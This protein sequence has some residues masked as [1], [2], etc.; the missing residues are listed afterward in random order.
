MSRRI[1]S[2]GGSGDT[3]RNGA[4]RRPRSISSSG[5]LDS[6]RSGVSD[7]PGVSD[8]PGSAPSSVPSADFR[9]VS[10]VSPDASGSGTGEA[11]A[12]AAGGGADTPRGM[13]PDDIL[14]SSRSHQG[15]VDARSL[16][17]DASVPERLDAPGD[18]GAGGMLLRPKVVSYPQRRKE[19]TMAM[20]HRITRR[21]VVLMLVAVLV[22][23]GGWVLFFSP[24]FRYDPAQT[25]LSGLN[26]WVDQDAVSRIIS[27]DS[28]SSLFLVH[29]E[30]IRAELDDLVGVSDV[31]VRRTFPHG[32]TVSLTSA[33]PAAVLHVTSD[34]TLVPVTA[35]G[36]RLQ[37]QSAP[38]A[39]NGIPRIDVSSADAAT[40]DA[41]IAEAIKVMGGFT[42]TLSPRV[43][44]TTA[45]TRD[46][47]TST[48]DDG[49]TVLWGDSED[50]DF[51]VSVVE[52]ILALKDAG[53][54]SYASITNINVS[55]A[56]S[57]IIK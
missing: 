17:P 8:T 2:S 45:A 4:A 36:E 1:V 50:I 56:D 15:F 38:G 10:G 12:E 41:A 14:V 53:D 24:V 18:G 40:N 13:L 43:T 48:I 55:S 47:V 33:E 31:T 3:P 29:S 9:G 49:V 6:V 28:G 42:D 51:K 54:A 39:Y 35:D 25:Q 26:Q 57:P 21:V 34:D 46:S 16:D 32:L 7:A 19:R 22:V 30:K 27:T 44:S 20:A 52:K 23:T 5:A 11:A 37:T